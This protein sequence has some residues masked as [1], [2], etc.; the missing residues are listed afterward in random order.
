MNHSSLRHC[1]HAVVCV[2]V[3]KALLSG[4]VFQMSRLLS[5]SSNTQIEKM[6]EAAVCQGI[7]VHLDG[8]GLASRSVLPVQLESLQTILTWLL[9]A[10]RTCADTAMITWV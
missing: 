9:E 8:K 4:S 6:A 3:A 10:Q 7:F 2:Q 1:V 5:D